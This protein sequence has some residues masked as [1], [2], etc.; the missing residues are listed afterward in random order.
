M[1]RSVQWLPKTETLVIV[2]QPLEV[3][4]LD[5]E[6]VYHSKRGRIVSRQ[7]DSGRQHLYD[8]SAA[9]HR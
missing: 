3:V 4:S 6:S 5:A 7:L 8:F 9:S 2:S 1:T